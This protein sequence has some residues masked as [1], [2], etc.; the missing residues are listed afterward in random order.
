MKRRDFLD[1]AKA[2][3]IITGGA[4]ITAC[5]KKEPKQEATGAPA[6]HTKKTFKWKMVTTW[7]PKF[8]IFQ[9]GVEKFAQRVEVMSHGRL[10]IKVYAGGELVPPLGVFDAVSQGS[11]EMGN[12]GAYY[13]AGKA[14]EA[15]FFTS[16]PFGFTAQQI[17]SW[18]YHG[19]GLEL[20]REV[21]A[22]YNLVPFPIANTGVQMGGWFNKRIDTV[23]DFE[24][25]KMRIPGVGGKV[26]AKAGVNVVLLAASE[27]YTSLERG[28]ID[29]VEWA[30]PYHD[31]QLGFY[32]A[33]KHYYYPGW[34]E[35]GSCIEL[36]V[37][38][39]A[40]ESLPTDLQTIIEAAAAETN[41]SSLAEFD[42]KNGEALETLVNKYN[43]KVE[44]FPD[45]VI[46]HLKQLSKETIEEIAA[47]DPKVKK[48]HDHFSA[49]SKKIAPWSEISERA[50]MRAK[51][52]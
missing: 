4:L 44:R 47:G 11:V 12:S 18:L 24:G 9:T 5:E 26:L 22:P 40:W 19:G 6:V 37:N 42:A 2:V 35:P 41:I 48:V 20:W 50:Y 16:I 36:T 29:A 32:R 49:F 38:K 43:V 1:K 27:L 28:V 34:H 10:S 17:N 14:P 46:R 51:T 45:E 3:A 15:Q 39:K 8:P 52:L 23:K 7:P 31:L 21:Y 13:W 33:A 25:L 30:G